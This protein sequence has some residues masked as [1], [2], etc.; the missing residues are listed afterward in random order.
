MLS[1]PGIT[2]P[3]AEGLFGENRIANGLAGLWMYGRLH[4]HNCFD[5][6]ALPEEKLMER[7]AVIQS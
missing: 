6:P 5:L 4:F 1:P 3:I 7:C 2:P